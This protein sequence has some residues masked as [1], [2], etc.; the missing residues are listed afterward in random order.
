MILFFKTLLLDHFVAV[1]GCMEDL[2][3]RRIASV[4]CKALLVTSGSVRLRAQKILAFF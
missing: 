2:K 3:T 1:D 4:F